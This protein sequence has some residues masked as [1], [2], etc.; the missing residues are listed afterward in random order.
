MKI[1]KDTKL[2]ARLHTQEN[3][4]GLNIYNPYFEDQSINAVYML[5]RSDDPR[6]LIEGMRNLGVSGAITA[7]FEHDPSL[8]GMVDELDE[9]V[10]VSGIIGNIANK[11]GKLRAHY[12]GGYGLLNAIQEKFDTTDKRIVVVGASTVV[13]TLLLAIE[14][15][16]QKPSQVIVVNRTLEHAQ[17]LQERFGWIKSVHSLDELGSIEGDILVN[18]SRIGSTFEDTVY[19]TEIIGRYAAVADVTFGNPITNLTTLAA[20][21]GLVV[22]NGWDM[23]THQAAV[24]LREVLGHDANIDRLRYF[25][26]QGL[27]ANNHGATL[28]PKV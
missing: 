16:S 10:E 2:I 19:K 18:A 20:Q 5:F 23:F 6:P 8:A 7:G 27:A 17:S 21:A 3:D 25:V 11:D 13:K 24:V 9:T 26:A 12:Q 22:I 14:K 4:T 15:T 1:D 28:K